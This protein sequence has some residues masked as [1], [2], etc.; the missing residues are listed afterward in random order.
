MIARN[1]VFGSASRSSLRRC[2]V[3]PLVAAAIT[4]LAAC[5]GSAVV[6][7]TSTPSTDTYLTYRVGLVSVALASSS[8]TTTSKTLP[9]ST[10]VDLANLVNLS[11]VLGATSVS[12]A[13][14]KSVVVTLD[15]SS[16]V[17]VYD[18]GSLNGL[19][20]TPVNSSGQPLGQVT[21]TLTLDPAY[22]FTVTSGKVSRLS[23][24]FKLAASN[25]VN[26]SAKTVTVTPVMAAS[27]GPIDSKQVRL[28]G[29]LKSVN[30]STGVFAQGVTPFDFPTASSGSLVVTASDATTYEI[31]GTASTGTT[32][33]TQ[34]GGAATGTMTE[35]FGT[36][37]SSDTTTTTTTDGTSTSTTST[38]LT[39][40]ATEVMAGT[41]VQSSTFDRVAG[42]VA[43]RSGNTVTIEDA[44]LIDVNG[45]NTFLSGTTTVT[46]GAGTLVTEYGQG[47]ADINSSAQVS[48]GSLIYAFG[49]ATTGNSG[50]ASLDASAGL[51]QLW[52]TSASGSV[53]VQGT[54]SLNLNLTQ[55]G[56][57][58]VTTSAF[59]F[60][61]SG[62]VANDYNVSTS[63]LVLTNSTV[64]VPVQ[65]T[66]F[67]AAF[68]TTSPN[69]TA[70]TLLD[71][72]TIDAEIVVDWGTGTAAPFTTYDDTAID[73][74]VRNANIGT[75]HVIQ[76]GSQ[77]VNLVGLSQDPLITPTATA[78]NM[79]FAIAHQVSGTVENFNTYDAFITQFTTELNGSTLATGM[80]ALGQ[81]TTSTYAFS[82]SSITLS[83]ND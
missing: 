17:I 67:T 31:N 83:L 68:G 58:S 2:I 21:L 43:A 11:E 45:N 50:N 78:A 9:S 8:G 26:T 30:T 14:Y 33:L 79:V 54:G 72:T 52:L 47:D 59:D 66:G 65:V 61:G 74:D 12:K 28:R 10:T 64:G 82:A 37:T 5:N 51:V 56:G 39:F 76:V 20:L 41:S 77:T 4:F 62:A 32:G 6:T 81:Y 38:D 55:L 27:A 15:Y 63:D 75:R 18:D 23:L 60:T 48:V 57:R 25:V 7:L 71:P 44:T 46:L 36:L 3:A 80:T 16:A 70:S 49:T 34:L 19:A 1:F 40:A 13:T 42:I 29:P 73:L 22:S 35:T 69:F 53:T 24:D